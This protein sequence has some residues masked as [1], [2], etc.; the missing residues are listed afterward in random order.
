MRYFDAD[1]VECLNAEQWQLD[2][3]KLNPEYVSWGPREDYMW[4]EG[5]GWS[6]SQ[7]FDTW[8]AFGPWSLDDLNECANFYF[9]VNRD[10]KGCDVC[11]GSGYH[12]Q[13]QHIANAFYAHMN[14]AGEHWNDKITQD[15]LDAL[16]DGGRLNASITLAEVNAQNAPGARGI[17]H[18]AINRHI[19]IQARIK[20]LGLPSSCDNCGGDGYVYT[21]P[22]A[23]ASLTLWM[24]HP[25]KGCSR[26]IE[27]K[28]IQQQ[29]LPAV[30]AWLREAAARN[31]RRFDAVVKGR[32]A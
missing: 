18:D 15:E 2:L 20:R 6:S 14:P 16:I 32:S 23:H 9:S 22:V 21:A 25:R 19:L 10:S 3:L 7:I 31:A 17:G 4:V 8:S 5:G 13:A 1:E 27:I 26:G 11:G 28:S 30:F 12:A 24:L 29:D